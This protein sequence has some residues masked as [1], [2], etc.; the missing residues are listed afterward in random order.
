MSLFKILYDHNPGTCPWCIAFT[1]KKEESMRIATANVVVTQVARERRGT[2][3]AVEWP[4]DG[5]N[6]PEPGDRLVVGW[7][8]DAVLGAMLSSGPSPEEQA[9]I[10]AAIA[11]VDSFD[12]IEAAMP[13]M[14][15]MVTEAFPDSAHGRVVG[16][17]K[18]LRE[19]GGR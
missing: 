10:D 19:K 8:F 13:G 14:M 3:V 4:K 18:A 16:A 2:R 12:R 1:P 11:L 7:S 6:P 9:V 17:V 5:H 15:S